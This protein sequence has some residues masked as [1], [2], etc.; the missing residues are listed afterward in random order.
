MSLPMGDFWHETDLFIDGKRVAAEGG[1][2][3]DNV[4]PATD[5]VIGVAADAS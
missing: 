1:A 4:N 3:Y 5:E 2:T